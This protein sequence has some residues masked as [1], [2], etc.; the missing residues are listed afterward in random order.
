MRRLIPAAIDLVCVLIFCAIGRGQHGEALDPLGMFTT[1]Y[2]FVIGWL[3]GAIGCVTQGRFWP[4]WM[5]ALVM[6]IAVVAIGM[7]ARNLMGQGVQVSFVIVATIANAL[8]LF[9][10]RAVAEFVGRSRGVR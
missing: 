4:W 1:A 10:W 8:L 3:S 6:T 7:A 9:G 5:H 2:P